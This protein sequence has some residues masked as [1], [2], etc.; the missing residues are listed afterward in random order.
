MNSVPGSDYAQRYAEEAARQAQMA[1]NADLAKRQAE[2]A[3]YRDLAART[4]S[5]QNTTMKPV[6]WQ[7]GTA[8]P[9]GAMTA[10]AQLNAE[11]ADKRKMMIYVGVGVGVVAVVGL[12]LY[13]IAYKG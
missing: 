1:A 3:A 13:N 11:A 4:A 2:A 5:P 10:Q 6:S 8:A 9:G 12:A 7:Y